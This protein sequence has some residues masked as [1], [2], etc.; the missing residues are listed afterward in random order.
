MVS[1][2]RPGADLFAALGD[3]ADTR[4]TCIDDD[5]RNGLG[6]NLEIRLLGQQRLHGL[7][8][9][10][11]IGLGARPAHRRTLGQIEHAELDAGAVDGA[12]HD[13][14]QGIDLAHQMAL[15]QARRWRDCRTSRRSYRADG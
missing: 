1:T 12:A 8:I 15:A 7:A 6:A 11:A 13:A 9:E 14:V 4:S 2:T 3:D 5:I 10:L